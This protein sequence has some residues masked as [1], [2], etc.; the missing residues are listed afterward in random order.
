MRT[1]GGV[2]QRG[3]KRIAAR[4][5]SEVSSTSFSSPFNG[6]H[7]RLAEGE[8]DGRWLDWVLF[9]KFPSPFSQFLFTS[10]NRFFGFGVLLLQLPIVCGVSCAFS[11]VVAGAWDTP[12]MW[13]GGDNMLARVSSN[14]M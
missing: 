1:R 14:P 4:Q 11:M 10:F 9:G 5:K 6:A 2:W 13:R 3:E 7:S 8:S 12:R